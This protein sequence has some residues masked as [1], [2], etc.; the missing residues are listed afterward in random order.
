MVDERTEVPHLDE[1]TEVPHLDERT[2]VP[3]LDERTE[4]PHRLRGAVV[5]I[6]ACTFEGIH[7]PRSGGQDTERGAAMV[8][9]LSF[10]AASTVDIEGT[11]FRNNSLGGGERP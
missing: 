10:L 4:V 6:R 9:M 1:R 2:E 5:R 7:L 8:I 11:T 3:H